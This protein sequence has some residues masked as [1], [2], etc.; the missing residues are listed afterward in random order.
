MDDKPLV[1]LAKAKI[2]LLHVVGDADDTVPVT[3]NT[4]IVVEKYQKLGGQITVIS[5]KAGY[6]PHGLDDPQPTVDF[7]MKSLKAANP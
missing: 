7:I 5:H 2:P 3:E 6:H 1:I 4:V